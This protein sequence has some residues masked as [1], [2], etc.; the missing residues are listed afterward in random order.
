MLH[1]NLDILI[2]FLENLYLMLAFMLECSSIPFLPYVPNHCSEDQLSKD[3]CVTFV[4]KLITDKSS[5][6]QYTTY[7]INKPKL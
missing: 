2:D 6:L 4:L 7:R 1:K 3:T 5:L